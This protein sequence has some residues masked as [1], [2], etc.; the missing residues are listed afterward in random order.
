MSAIPVPPPLPLRDEDF[1]AAESKAVNT[2]ENDLPSSERDGDS[3]DLQK[4][5]YDTSAIDP[6]LAKKMALTNNAIDEIGMT[7]WQWKLFCL[8]GFGYAVD[9]VRLKHVSKLSIS[10]IPSLS[11]AT[12]SLPVDRATGRDT[13]IWKPKQAHC[14]RGPRFPDWTPGWRRALGIQC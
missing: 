8:N 3:I 9:S 13:R 4:E 1:A 14:W 7:P 5:I 10:L 2:K 6:V 12:H 11:P